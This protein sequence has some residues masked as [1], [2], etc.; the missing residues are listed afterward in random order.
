MPKKSALHIWR[1]STLYDLEY[2]RVRAEA[3]SLCNKDGFDRGMEPNDLYKSWRHF[4]LPEKHN[5]YG[6]EVMCEVVMC[7][8]RDLCKP[9]HGPEARRPVRPYK[10]AWASTYGDSASDMPGEEFNSW[11]V[12]KHES[13]PST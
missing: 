6:H 11:Y 5:R 13:S 2:K 3:Q 12:A 4:M 9:G 7:E 10:E 8:I 1:S